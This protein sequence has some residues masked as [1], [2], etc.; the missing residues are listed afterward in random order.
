MPESDQPGGST[1]QI[2]TQMTTT[3]GQ[4]DNFDPSKENWECYFERFEKFTLIKNIAPERQVACLFAVIGPSTYGIQRNLVYPEKPKDKSLDEISN[5]LEE[6]FIL[7]FKAHAEPA[8]VVHLHKTILLLLQYID[9]NFQKN[10][11]TEST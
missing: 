11:G 4:L 1:P 5:I 7:K 6:R 8:K 9:G 2:P 10:P 3:V